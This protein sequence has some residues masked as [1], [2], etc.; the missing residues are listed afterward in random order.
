MQLSASQKTLQDSLSQKALHAAALFRNG[1]Y[2]DAIIHLEMTL[3]K[4]AS[5]V[6]YALLSDF[7]FHLNNIPKALV[8]IKNA[9]EI[10]SEN[11]SLQLK[12]VNL[13]LEAES[14][15]FCQTCLE[16]IE[17]KSFDS[18][19]QFEYYY[20]FS[21]TLNQLKDYR[22][23]L[24]YAEQALEI[25]QDHF[26]INLL[27]GE[28][29]YKQSEFEQAKDYFQKAL[30][31]NPANHNA[32]NY[33]SLLHNALGLQRE[34][35]WF[36]LKLLRIRKLDDIFFNLACSLLLIGKYDLG[37]KFYEK[38][39]TLT[40]E[41]L[42]TII[43]PI[44]WRGESLDH[45]TLLVYS[46]QGYGDNIQFCRF[47]KNL[48]AKYDCEIIYVVREWSEVLMHSLSKHIRIVSEN[49]LKKGKIILP[50]CDFAILLMSLLQHLKVREKTY[51]LAAPYLKSTQDQIA[52]YRKKIKAL[53]L[54][55][56]LKVGL[57][58]A[59]SKDYGNDL[60]RSL[61]AEKLLPLFD[62]QSIAF[63]NLQV[64]EK[65]HDLDQYDLKNFY[66][67]LP[68]KPDFN[69]SAALIEN[70]DLVISVDTAIAHLSGALF[71]PVWCLINKDPDWR[72]GLSENKTN[73][74]PTMQLF[75][76]SN[77]G[78]WDE[79]I[80]RVNVQLKTF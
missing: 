17:I 14:Y 61:S 74:Y 51:H 60:N 58:W 13:F 35:I 78:D 31:I 15:E 10:D 25:D 44:L 3:S 24:K 21:R 68:E 62:H 19:I 50:K 38:R 64:N 54:K 72:W 42:T 67:L 71:K 4:H 73:W 23:A 9:C 49:D 63:F 56:N 6:D 32:L 40:A 20:L 76:Q 16:N 34:A 45:K 5:A 29:A 48:K 53:N 75:K 52:F 65:R 1:M 80:Q 33:F 59:G 11:I 7:Y 41:K 77:F 39:K 2:S 26:G 69:V 37:L 27:A 47:I 28:I 70:L 22:P 55:A 8:A 30:I 18:E 36:Y 46:E 66:H 12:L 43:E 79:V 57:V